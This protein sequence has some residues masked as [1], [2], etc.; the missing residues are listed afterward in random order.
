MRNCE[1]ICTPPMFRS[2]VSGLGI[3]TQTAEDIQKETER[4]ARITPALQEYQR[5]MSVWNAG[6]AAARSKCPPID[7][8]IRTIAPIVCQPVVD[9]TRVN[10][11][12]TPPEGATKWDLVWAQT[13]PPVDERTRLQVCPPVCGNTVP[14]GKSPSTDTPP[15]SKPAGSTLPLL[16]GAAFLL[17]S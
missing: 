1:C 6:V 14:S 11:Q 15:T 4:R 12:P 13:L 10:P 16:L 3:T 9:Y 5:K 8:N 2:R 17:L 7:P